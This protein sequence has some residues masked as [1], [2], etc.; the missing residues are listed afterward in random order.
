MPFFLI[1][2]P[3]RHA[4]L[5][6]RVSRISRFPLKN[7]SPGACPSDRLISYGGIPHPTNHRPRNHRPAMGFSRITFPDGRSPVTRAPSSVC[8]T[9]VTCAC[10]C[11]CVLRVYTSSP[12]DSWA[13]VHPPS[14]VSRACACPVSPVPPMRTHISPLCD[15]WVC[16]LSPVCVCVCACMGYA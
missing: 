14:R 16:V 1:A 11:V 3:A 13:C 12:C 8:V 2:F 7:P 5:V 9:R 10:A 4:S 6:S 15:P